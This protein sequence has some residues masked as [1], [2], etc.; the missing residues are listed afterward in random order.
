MT[1]EFEESNNHTKKLKKA[2]IKSNSLEDWQQFTKSRNATNHLKTKLKAECIKNSISSDP[3]HD[4]KFAWDHFNKETG[5]KKKGCKIPHL[6]ENGVLITNKLKKLQL[7]QSYFL[8]DDPF[9]LQKNANL[10]S[11]ADKSDR[12]SKIAFTEKQIIDII[13]RIEINKPAGHDTIPPKFYKTCKD[14]IVPILVP[15]FNEMM[16]EGIVPD[17]MKQTIIGAFTKAKVKSPTQ[18]VIA[19]YLFYQQQQKSLRKVST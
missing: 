13:V 14:E 6:K 8:H 17:A 16:R 7:L 1:P 4:S 10:P 11:L 9:P 5:R 2:H 18:K 3:T 12:L 19:L 15:L